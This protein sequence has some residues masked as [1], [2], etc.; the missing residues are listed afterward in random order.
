SPDVRCAN[1]LVVDQLAQRL[2]RDPLA[3]RLSFLRN[4]RV[5]AVLEK[6]AT[7]GGWGRRMEP[8]T[9][10]GIAIHAEY[11]G[12]TACLVEIDCRPETVNRKVRDAVTGPR[13]T[14]A[15]LGIDAGLVVNPT[16]LEAQMMGG[17]AD[18]LALTL[19][20]SLHLQDGHFLEASWDNYFYTRQW[21]IPPD[22]EVVIMPSTSAQPG[23]AGEAGVAASGAAVACAYTRATGQLPKRFPI[24]HNDP[25]S[26]DVKSFVPPVPASPTNGLQFTY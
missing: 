7:V 15:V 26:F 9:A 1:E 23:G 22:F 8:G 17:F 14:K 4:K 25:I 2:G 5:R 16:G 3:F 12:A 21:N 11:K 20:S 18:G 19:T 24:N 6:V 13:V 10:Q